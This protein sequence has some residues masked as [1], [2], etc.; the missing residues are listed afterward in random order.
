[1][2]YEDK[3]T[4]FTEIRTNIEDIDGEKAKQI[5]DRWYVSKDEFFEGVETHWSGTE[6]D[7]STVTMDTPC[8]DYVD[9]AA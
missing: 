6:K 7:I 1:M 9:Y 4:Y 5:I 2:S 3:D 8:G